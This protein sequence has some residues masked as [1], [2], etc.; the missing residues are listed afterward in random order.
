MRVIFQV[1]GSKSPALRAFTLIEVLTAIAILG[2]LVVVL[3]QMASL[4]SS[5]WVTAQG[6]L[7]RRQTAR[8]IADFIAADLAAVLLPL[9]PA[10][11][12]SF[13]LNPDIGEDLKNPSAVFWLAPV[14][15]DQTFGDIAEVGYFVRWDTTNSTNPRA[16]L[17]RFLVNPDPNDA[18]YAVLQNPKNWISRAQIDEVAPADKNHDYKGLFAEDVVGLWI[19]CLGMNPDGTP[20]ELAGAGDSLDSGQTYEYK[21]PTTGETKVKHLPLAVEVSLAMLDSRSASRIGPGEMATIRSLA[22]NAKN[23]GEFVAQVLKEDSLR[24]ISP[25]MHAF[26]TTTYLINSK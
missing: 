21:D 6:Q 16:G 5:S 3:G 10:S 20:K 13:F 23:A 15:T 9:D 11:T 4:V 22:G 17:C 8:S 1:P 2:L 7:E 12:T 18:N 24:G 19:R 26:A 14:A 25:G